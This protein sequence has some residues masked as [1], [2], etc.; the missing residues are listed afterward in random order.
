MQKNV[1]NAKGLVFVVIAALAGSAVI[2]A[3]GKNALALVVLAVSVVGYLIY[4]IGKS[5]L[6]GA[7]PE[8]EQE[9]REEQKN[10]EK[11]WEKGKVPPPARER[12]T[13]NY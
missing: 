7:E 4:S 3:T 5:G 1:K 8:A 11:D 10:N 12:I 6:P 13:S 9:Q 2:F